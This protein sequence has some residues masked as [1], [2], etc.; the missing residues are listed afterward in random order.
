MY[1][2]RYRDAMSWDDDAFDELVAME[3]YYRRRARLRRIWAG[4]AL[5]VAASMLVLYVLSDFILAS[6]RSEAPPTVPV[7]VRAWADP[8]L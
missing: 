8:V 1:G 7:T 3:H 5:L 4:I 6:R 2:L